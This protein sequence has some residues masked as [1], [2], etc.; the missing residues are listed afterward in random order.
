MD[1]LVYNDGEFHT[2]TSLKHTSI[3]MEDVFP[4]L[5]CAI[6]INPKTDYGV[7]NPFPWLQ[8]QYNRLR[9]ITTGVELYLFPECADASAKCHFHGYVRIHDPLGYMFFLKKLGEYG[10]FCIKHLFEPDTWAEYVLKQSHL[11]V[12][13]F[14][15]HNAIFGY[16]MYCVQD[17]TNL[18]YH[19]PN[20]NLGVELCDTNEN[21]KSSNPRTLRGE[22]TNARPGRAKKAPVQLFQNME[23]WI[24]RK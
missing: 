6:S 3:P 24:I 1:K 8:T 10:T 23:Q 21:L 18:Y 22:D 19:P 14:R 20:Y 13:S 16:P 11:W 17:G 2:Y 9:E 4:G 5:L 12:P 15:Q 7:L